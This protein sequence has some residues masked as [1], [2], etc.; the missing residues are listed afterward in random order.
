[1]DS[2]VDNV[3]FINYKSLMDTQQIRLKPLTLIVGANSSGKT[4][5]LH[6]FLLL[7]QTLESRNN[8][9]PLIL[10]GK[11]VDL[12]SYRDIICFVDLTETFR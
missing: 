8:E 1:M 7:K 6:P 10:R 3:H 2:V 12:S 4:A 5:F 11:Y 9:A